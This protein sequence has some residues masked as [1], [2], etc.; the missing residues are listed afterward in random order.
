MEPSL[1][2][3]VAHEAGRL[4]S[5]IVIAPD[6]GFER[7]V[8]IKGEGPPI[9]SR[10]R[11]QHDVFVQTLRRNRVE[12]IE[13]APDP[14]FA[15]A[16][17]VRSTA[18]ALPGGIV[19]GRLMQRER[20]GEEEDVRALLSKR[21]LPVLGAVEAPGA[22]DARDAVVMG[23]RIIAAQT[24]STNA[25]GIEQLAGFARACGLEVREA[26]LAPEVEHLGD[27]FSPVGDELVVAVPE[28]V[29]GAALDGVAVVAIPPELRW[30]AGC[31]ALGPRHVIM[32]L[33]LPK[34]CAIVKKA[35][36]AVEAIDLYDFG[37]VAAGPWALALPLRRAPLR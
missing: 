28:L 29:R 16:T 37:R 22:L 33:R 10:A 13:L 8:P 18:L 7:A 4:S 25:S 23:D 1:A 24:A 31:L 27:V 6:A 3:G 34:A 26:T 36:I 19:I 17:L 2:I 9:A 14:R 30:A 12:V 21:G 35:K 11:A 5:A 20:R 15:L 32:D